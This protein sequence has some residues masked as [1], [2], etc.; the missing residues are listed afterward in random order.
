MCIP[1]T[2]VPSERIFSTSGNIVTKL[3]ASLKPE[4]VDMLVFLH[5]N[6][7]T[8]NYVIVC[9]VNDNAL[10]TLRFYHLLF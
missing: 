8:V 3:R 9:I 2:S 10:Y 5:K 7:P 6:L 1:A 4:N